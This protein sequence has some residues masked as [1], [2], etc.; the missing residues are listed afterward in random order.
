MVPNP[1]YF[2]GQVNKYLPDQCRIFNTGDDLDG[3]AVFSANTCLLEGP[4]SVDALRYSDFIIG[5]RWNGVP[6]PG[7]LPL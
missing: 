4:L 6:I 7:R 2:I 5:G 3:T 1:S